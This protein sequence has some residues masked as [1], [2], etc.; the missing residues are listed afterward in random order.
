MTDR[1]LWRVRCCRA[2]RWTGLRTTPPRTADAIRFSFLLTIAASGSMGLS[3]I[4]MSAFPLLHIL[5][6]LATF[7]APK[8]VNVISVGG[9][10]MT[11]IYR[12]TPAGWAY[13]GQV[14]TVQGTKVVVEAKEKAT[15][16]KDVKE[17]IQPVL[18]KTWDFN[19]P[20]S[21]SGMM[22]IEK[23]KEGY[24]V[25]VNAGDPKEEVYSISYGFSK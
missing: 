14:W 17:F 2:W 11:V 20:L 15:E 3:A 7:F 21:L 13:N 22:K 6:F 24:T 10:D 16:T 19:S 23:S 9:P 25:K 4:F 12:Q 1:P 8:D 18:A 5:F